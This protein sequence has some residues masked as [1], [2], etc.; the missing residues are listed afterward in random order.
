[1]IN[2]NY[3]KR[4]NNRLKNWDYSSEGAYF[5]TVCTDKHKNLFSRISVGAIRESPLPKRSLIS[6]IVGYLKMNSSKEIH[7]FSSID[8]I[9]QRSF[10]D[11]I[12]RSDED[13]LRIAEYIYNNPGKWEEDCFYKE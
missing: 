3:P 13:Y 5:I 2:S 11:H 1:M 12:I 9:W 8:K 7:K 6:N 4:K 10:H